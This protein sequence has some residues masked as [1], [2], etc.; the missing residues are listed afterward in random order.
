MFGFHFNFKLGQ[1]IRMLG[2]GPFLLTQSYPIILIGNINIHCILYF[3]LKQKSAKTIRIYI[4]TKYMCTEILSS[5]WYTRNRIGNRIC[6]CLQP[7]ICFMNS[8]CTYISQ[9]IFSRWKKWANEIQWIQ[10]NHFLFATSKNVY[11][12]MCLKWVKFI[13]GSRDLFWDGF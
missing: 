13:L 8:F 12:F 3:C 9:N 10:N 11:T 1:P 4:W 7:E 5:Q 6:T 2:L